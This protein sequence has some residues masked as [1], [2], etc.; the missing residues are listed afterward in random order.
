MSAPPSNAADVDGRA[1]A[2]LAIVLSVVVIVLV[3]AGYNVLLGLIFLLVWIPGRVV[4]FYLVPVGLTA[5][6]A[7]AVHQAVRSRRVLPRIF[8]GAAVVFALTTFV[9]PQYAQIVFANAIG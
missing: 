6:S 9:V 1:A 5:L 8:A 2:V 4:L 3:V 7:V